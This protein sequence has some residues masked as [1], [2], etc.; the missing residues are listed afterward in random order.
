MTDAPQWTDEPQPEAEEN[1]PARRRPA[2]S[3]R[4]RNTGSFNRATARKVAAKA[5]ELSAADSA[6]LEVLAT[7]IGA[8]PDVAD[9]TAAVFAQGPGETINLSL[10]SEIL[11]ADPAMRA[12]IFLTADADT[13]KSI[14]SALN[15]LGV[16]D[17]RTMP[18]ADAKA[19]TKIV[20]SEISY[21]M[22]E[23]LDRIADLAKRG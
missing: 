6:D 13:K 14:W 22:I 23:R 19:A 10:V 20:S 8:S 16:L 11:A 18:N 1:K 3:K 9:L 7:V 4:A 5:I 15:A 21:D 2:T 17:T 12:I